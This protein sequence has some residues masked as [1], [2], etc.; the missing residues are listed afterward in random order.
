[1][2]NNKKAKRLILQIG[3]FILTLATTTLAGAEWMTGKFLLL[4]DDPLTWT[5]FWRGLAYSIPFLGILTVHEFGHYFMA[6]YH[7]VRVTLPFY[8]PLWLGFIGSVSIGTMGA[9]IK[10]KDHI[11][12]RKKYFDIG[13]AGPL[14]G[15]VIALFVLAY[16]FST[17][18]DKDFIYNIHPDYEQFGERYEEDVYSY[19]YNVF[20]HHQAYKSFRAEDSTTYIVDHGSIEDWD[21]PEFK[22]FDTYE[23]YAMGTTL[24]FDW[25]KVWFAKDID[26]V[27]NKFEIMHYPFLFA[28]FLAL[29]FTSLNLIPIGQLDGG[30]ILYGLVGAKYHKP[31]AQVLF[32]GFMYFAG[33]GLF[34]PLEF[35]EYMLSEMIYVGF[36]FLSFHKFTT[37]VKEKV[38]YAVAVVALQLATV[39]VF[40]NAEGYSGWL[41]FGFVIGRFLGVYHPPVLIN[42]PLDMKR[43]ILGWFSLFVFVISVSPRPFEI[44][45]IHKSEVTSDTP[46]ILS[47]TNP[48]PYWERMDMPNS[49]ALPS[50]KCINSKDEI[51]VSDLAPSGSKNWDL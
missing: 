8:I 17:L 24:L 33:L 29:F 51:S 1:M 36:L 39:I 28:G 4:G 45:E 37:D 26:L 49:L 20:R 13:I 6:K 21:F 38:M 48:S 50:K 23:S 5:D 27:P 47:D 35:S 22:P 42:Q 40:P 9:L 32:V 16:G 41:L 18:P 12:D 44:V 2:S 15:F 19:E 46:N 30:H 34:N 25:M 11:I 7:K 43:Q 3:L 10:I 31:I 14:A